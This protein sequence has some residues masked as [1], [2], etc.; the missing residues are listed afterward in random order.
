M[1]DHGEKAFGKSDGWENAG[2]DDVLSKE[3]KVYFG[4]YRR[5][6]FKHSAGGRRDHFIVKKN[7]KG[8]WLPINEVAFAGLGDITKNKEGKIVAQVLKR[9]KDGQPEKH[10]TDLVLD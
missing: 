7:D 2:E 4:L 1:A 10:M 5:A 6:L 3:N 8:E 9:D